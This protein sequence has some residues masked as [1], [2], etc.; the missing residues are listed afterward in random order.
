MYRERRP[1]LRQ[2]ALALGSLALLILVAGVALSGGGG[3]PVK[4]RIEIVAEPATRVAAGGDAS[5]E[6]LTR[7]D[8]TAS[9]HVADVGD[10]GNTVPVATIDGPGRRLFGAEAITLP[11]SGGPYRLRQIALADAGSAE[12]PET[13]LRWQGYVAQLT[14]AEAKGAR[15]RPTLGWR[16]AD[17]GGVLVPA[18]ATVRLRT[19]FRIPRSAGACL[20]AAAK[21]P[22]A[23]VRARLRLRRAPAWLI[24]RAGERQW[25]WLRVRTGLEQMRTVRTGPR[26]PV[27]FRGSRSCVKAPPELNVD[28]DPDD[29]ARPPDSRLPFETPDGTY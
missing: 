11:R 18:G 8:L 6:G 13:F 28:P 23:G 14:Q 7:P 10:G 25:Q 15:L 9:V 27:V 5:G 4:S 1:R 29:L 20:G 24:R 3:D 2:I 17:E 12:E 22:A 21:P 16:A 19:M 26:S